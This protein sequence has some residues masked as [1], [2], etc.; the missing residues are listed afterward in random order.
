MYSKFNRP[1]SHHIIVKYNPKNS[2]N[3]AGAKL[4]A[5]H[6]HGI[7]GGPLFRALIDDNDRL[8][9]LILEGI[10][11]EWKDKNYAVATS[12]KVLRDFIDESYFK[13]KI[14]T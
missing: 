12:K 3:Q 1:Q 7:S 9:V 14:F 10:L 6:P 8:Q 5:P 11:T 4:T 2:K 13:Q